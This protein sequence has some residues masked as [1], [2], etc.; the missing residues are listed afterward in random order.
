MTLSGSS[1]TGPSATVPASAV[2]DFGT[3]PANPSSGVSYC[4]QPYWYPPGGC[5]DPAAGCSFAGSGPPAAGW[6]SKAGIDGSTVTLGTFE[7][8]V[9]ACQQVAY[10]YP[11]VDGWWH[12][13]AFYNWQCGDQVVET[14]FLAWLITPGGLQCPL[15]SNHGDWGTGAVQFQVPADWGGKLRL[16]PELFTYIGSAGK[17]RSLWRAVAFE[18]SSAILPLQGDEDGC[19]ALGLTETPTG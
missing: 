13:T 4:G 10:P 5:P 3:A 2:C 19:A 1:C 7:D 8:P 11:S 12:T 14:D 16:M 9:G 15:P 17:S 18:R 6:T